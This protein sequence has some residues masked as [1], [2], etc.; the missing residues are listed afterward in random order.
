MGYKKL[1]KK[2]I[3][4]IISS[5]DILKE[6]GNK[7]EK[8][9]QVVIDKNPLPYLISSYGRVLSLNYRGCGKIKFMKQKTSKTG[10]KLISFKVD[11]KKYF[12]SIHRLVATAFIKNPENKPEVNHKDGIKKH[13]YVWNLEWCTPKENI[14]HAYDHNLKKVRRG[15]EIGDN[16]F[17]EKMVREV[18]KLLVENKLSFKEIAKKTGVTYDM[19]RNI[20]SHKS[21]THISKDYNFDHYNG[22]KGK[23]YE[24]K[25]E[26][27]IRTIC[28]LLQTGKYSVTDISEMMGCKFSLVYNVARKR[29]YTDISREYNIDNYYKPK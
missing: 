4:S 18:C 1:S 7:K 24:K 10:Y 21:W 29:W 26:K 19:I 9:K 22:G 15:E 27:R 13:N 2:E 25:K 14:Q 3:K 28:I 11:G 17:T 5:F 12:C 20:R 16:K 23:D 6:P 8:F